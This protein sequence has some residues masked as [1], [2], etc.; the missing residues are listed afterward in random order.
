M[1]GRD[2][3][4][5]SQVGVGYAQHTLSLPQSGYQL[6][7]LRPFLHP[8]PCC[9]GVFKITTIGTFTEKTEQKLRGEIKYDAKAD[10]YLL[11]CLLYNFCMLRYICTSDFSRHLHT[12]ALPSVCMAKNTAAVTL[13]ESWPCDISFLTRWHSSSL[14][15]LA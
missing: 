5:K 2:R 14:C 8:S 4:T 3:T 11:A 9:L 13:R 7:T 12:Y 1:V 10:T 6:M 15:T